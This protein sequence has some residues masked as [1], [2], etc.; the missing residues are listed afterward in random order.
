MT[1]I[2]Q[3]GD[4]A[5]N[6][7][8]SNPVLM[9]REVGW[10]TDTRKSKLG[11]GVSPWNSLP[12][13]MVDIPVTSVNGHLGDVTLTKMDVGLSNVNNTA[14]I[15][16]PL[17]TVA[18]A[19]LATKADRASPVFT[20]NPT[21]PTPAPGDNDT[22]LATTAFVQQALAAVGVGTQAITCG[23]G[24]AQQAQAN[25]TTTVLF[26]SSKFPAAPTGGLVLDGGTVTVPESGWYRC[27][28]NV[29][30]SASLAGNRRIL[31]V[32]KGTN[33]GALSEFIGTN[34]VS[35]APSESNMS[36]LAASADI[37]CAAGEVLGAAVLSP[38]TWTLD[39]SQPYM[40]N[41]SVS[42]IR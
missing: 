7:Q 18:Q 34:T 2:K 15:D 17:S 12:Y 5:A 42:R 9:E 11:D 4:T 3:R 23:K 8:F 1:H 21:A 20:G 28:A 35:S 10:E 38:I 24:T 32:G 22:S 14:D 37:W 25:T 26:S 40:N 16:K 41:L 13:T 19:A 30:F 33:P 27:S 6:W 31:W 29:T 36:T 39:V